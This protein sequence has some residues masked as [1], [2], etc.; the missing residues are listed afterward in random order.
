MDKE[1]IDNILDSY[2]EECVNKLMSSMKDLFK[3]GVETGIQFSIE[4]LKEGA[5][6]MSRPEA[7]DSAWAKLEPTIRE[8]IKGL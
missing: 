6:V 2:E 4:T 5:R 1:T 7:I 3:Q 8:M